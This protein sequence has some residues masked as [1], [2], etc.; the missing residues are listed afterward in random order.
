MTLALRSDDVRR[1]ERC[2]AAGGVAV[3]PTD[4]VYGVCCDPDD[5]RAARRVYALKGRPPAR[6]AAVMFGALQLARERLADLLPT[7][8][9]AL[10]ALLPGPVT[11]L[12]PNRARRFAPAC[13]PDPDTL[14]VRVPRLPAR[15]AALALLAR[16]LLQTSANLSGRPDPRVLADVPAAL[17]E[18]ADLELDGGELPGTPSTVLD[19]RRYAAH[20][21]WSL[22]REGALA[23]SAVAELLSGLA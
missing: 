21:E 14:G 17:R 9:D 1:L 4:T 22:V 23:E 19:L 16:P 10:E 3:F 11:L 5:A 6:P 7:E 15:L 18:G 12:L 2:V 13:G 8:L 20:G